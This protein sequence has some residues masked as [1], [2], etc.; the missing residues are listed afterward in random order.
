MQWIILNRHLQAIQFVFVF[1][2]PL[3]L[4]IRQV[5]GT[6]RFRAHRLTVCPCTVYTSESPNSMLGCFLI[7]T[8]VKILRGYQSRLGSLQEAAVTIYRTSNNLSMRVPYH[9]LCGLVRAEPQITT[10]LSE[11]SACLNCPEI[12]IQTSRRHRDIWLAN[13]TPE[14]ENLGFSHSNWWIQCWRRHLHTCCPPMEK[15][16]TA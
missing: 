4:G 2:E 11:L 9:W 5:Q 1:P 16:T 7:V 6:E 8:V 10:Y 12:R 3:Y 15:P 14:S 13:G